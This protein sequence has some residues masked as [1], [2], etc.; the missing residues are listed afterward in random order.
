M[1]LDPIVSLAVAIAEKP[2]SFAFL[3]GSG[4]SQDA[5][6][7]TGGEVFW[8]AVAELYRLEQV[9]ADTPDDDVLRTWLAESGRADLR[10]SDVLELVAPDSATRRDYLAKHFEGAEPGA[11]HER[12]A[13]MA[14]DGL[15]SVFV[16]TNFDRLLE[17]AL[18]ARGIE[19]VVVTSD[20]DLV[21]APRREHARCWVLKAHGDY[22]QQTIRNTPAELAELEPEVT[23]ELRE[24][25]DRYGVV[26]LGYSGADEAIASAMRRRR[27]AYGLY[28]VARSEL[29][30]PARSLV[31]AVGGRVITRPTASAFVADLQRR[32]DVFAAQP[33]GLTPVAVNDQVVALLR[34]NDRVGLR[35]LLRGERRAFEETVLGF[36]E[37]HHQ[38]G[39]TAELAREA[40]H[41]LVPALERRLA[42]LAPLVL[43]DVAAFAE[44]ADELAELKGR[45]P[46]RG[47][48]TFW[49]ELVDWS[50]WWLSYTLGALTVRERRIDALRPLMQARTTNRYDGIEPLVQSVPGSGGH[51]LATAVMAED[52][53]Q[54]WLAPAFEALRRDLALSELL[55]ERY[56]EIVVAEGE[57][58]RSLIAFDFIVSIALGVRDVRA[59]A[60]WTMYSD[61]AAA[62][63][64]RLHGDARLRTAIA[65]ALGVTLAEFDERAPAAL[66]AVH[67]MGR[68]GGD[69]SAVAVLQ[70]GKY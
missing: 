55:R 25:L 54:R 45:L 1:P 12:L 23:R 63:A 31:E 5:G 40:H 34:K 21:A 53:N 49:P 26:V 52:G 46:V 67:A 64:R 62:F 47:G 33:S 61:T 68:F 17:R 41:V 50:L 66:A 15:V 2:A 9:T 22:L 27:S 57:P 56:P 65:E 44:E 39:P 32:L 69:L 3:L 29:V 10:Y 43:H 16:T 60:H 58:L 20:A 19:P 14:A 7:P 11:T 28:W 42:S 38:A 13:D 37:G 36:V 59:A 70:T 24:V 8:Q 35:E 30:E 51:E 4:V 48:Y 6:V 18:Q